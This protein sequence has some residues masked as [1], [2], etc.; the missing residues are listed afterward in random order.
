[1]RLAN[2]TYLLFL[3]A[4]SCS[5]PGGPGA[6]VKKDSVDKSGYYIDSKKP[7]TSI[8]TGKTTPAE[9]ISFARSL[10]GIPYKYGSTDPSRGF[11]CSGFISYVFN[12][13]GIIVPR[14]SVDFTSMKREIGVKEAKPGDLILFTGTDSTIRVVGHM[15]IIVSA[16][17]EEI[18]FIHSTSGRANG[19]T[20]SFLK[21]YYAGRY[22]KTIRIFP[23]NDHR[24][25]K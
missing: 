18:K 4:L 14:Q 25:V 24:I 21:P 23:Q 17:G 2:Y 3:A 1:M 12:H 13:F 9:L 6:A 5:H 7:I 15:G 8:S 19:V 16:P 22:M 11:D 10:K 20:E